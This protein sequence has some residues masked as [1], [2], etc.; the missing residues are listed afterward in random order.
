MGGILLGGLL[1][2]IGFFAFSVYISFRNK[3]SKSKE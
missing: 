3:K 2:L 1:L